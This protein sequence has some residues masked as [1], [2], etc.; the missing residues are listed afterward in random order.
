MLLQSILYK[1]HTFREHKIKYEN[2]KKVQ[3]KGRKEKRWWWG[4]GWGGGG[5]VVARGSV[6]NLGYVGHTRG[7]GTE[8][9]AAALTGIE[10]IEGRKVEN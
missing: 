8:A 9:T 3:D 6:R 1:F 2:I 4:G 5:G 7:E 10:F